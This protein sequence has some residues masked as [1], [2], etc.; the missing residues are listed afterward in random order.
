MF[1]PIRIGRNEVSERDLFLV[2]APTI[3]KVPTV[4]DLSSKYFGIL[5]VCDARTVENA[6]MA[7]IADSLLANGMKYFCSWGEECERM[8]DLVDE[9]IVGGDYEAKD[10]VI[11]TMWFADE[12]LDEALWQF[13]YVA[14][15]AAEYESDCRADLIIA[16]GNSEWEE[17]IKR[18]VSDLNGLNRDV[19]GDDE[20]EEV[21]SAI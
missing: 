2:G 18:R 3:D 21:E 9:V 15:P 11:M 19:V 12:S 1:Q 17:Q 6:V 8:H 4:F 5:L 14:F 20:S 10:S 7:K 16:I 13:L